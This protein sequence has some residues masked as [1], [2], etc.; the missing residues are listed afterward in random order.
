MVILSRHLVDDAEIHEYG[1]RQQDP[2]HNPLVHRL[3]LRK[4]SDRLPR[5]AG[6]GG[7]IIA[8][9]GGKIKLSV[10]APLATG[11]DTGTGT[12]FQMQSICN[13]GLPGKKPFA[14]EI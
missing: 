5:A 14:L 8:A 13:C 6:C 1:R 4:A 2:S 7:G 9:A 12:D 11:G 10:M 3:V